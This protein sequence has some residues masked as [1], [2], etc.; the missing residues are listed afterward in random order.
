VNY[1]LLDRG[2]GDES[3]DDEADPDDPPPPEVRFSTCTH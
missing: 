3:D 2:L 1:K